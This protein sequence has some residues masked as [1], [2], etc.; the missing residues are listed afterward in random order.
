MDWLAILALVFALVILFMLFW[1]EKDGYLFPS[2]Y[3]WYFSSSVYDW[4]LGV[5]DR[6][7][8][9]NHGLAH[10]KT[11][12]AVAEERLAM[13]EAISLRR[14][15][16]EPKVLGGRISSLTNFIEAWLL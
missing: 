8:T 14:S 2:S 4:S 3:G 16:Q 7:S 13:T 12:K 11:V 15:R 9:A 1:S 10:E 6:F 5:T